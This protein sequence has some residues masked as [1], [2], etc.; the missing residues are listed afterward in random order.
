MEIEYQQP[1]RWQDDRF[2]LRFPMAT[3]PRYRPAASARVQEQ[4]SLGGGWE[5][6][7]GEVP[8][9]VPL[10]PADE[11]RATN[12]ISL[13]VNLDPGFPLG[14]LVSRYHEI[15]RATAADGSTEIRLRAGAVPADRDFL[16]E[17]TAAE[18]S[19]PRAA[20]FTEHAETGDYGL[21]MVMPPNVGEPS[22]IAREV[23]FIIDTSGSMGG[24]S[25]RQAK[26]A[27]TQAIRGLDPEDRFEVIEFSSQTRSLFAGLRNADDRYTAEALG[28]VAGL[29]ADGG[30]EMKP[31]LEAAFA[32][33][34]ADARALRQI[35]FI[36]D[37]AVANEAELL[38]L[39][40]RRLGG[41]RLFTVG[42]GSAPN[43]YFMTEAAHAGRGSFT[44]IGNQRE[45]AEKMSRL[46][47]QLEQPAMTDPSLSLPV[48]ADALPNPLP[49]LYQGQP[50]V[51]VMR[52]DAVPD[53]AEVSGRIGDTDWQSRLSLD[54]AQ[55]QAGLGVYWAR[56]K[57]RQWMRRLHAGADAEQVRSEVTAIGL[58]H[59]L[60]SAYT[61]L[62]AVDVT[63]IR[64]PDSGGSTHSIDGNLPA[65]W[66]P[67]GTPIH[68]GS[69]Q[70]LGLAQGATWSTL[71]TLLG[72]LLLGLAGLLRFGRAV[73][74]RVRA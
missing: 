62:V 58:S 32:I 34:D 22:V 7:P 43:S 47:R 40:R 72:G 15:D 17:W 31:A 28:Y 67:P 46:F 25:I 6:L 21:L 66:Q 49:D 4:I 29:D 30:T 1:L 33:P 65:G 60:V 42:I 23:V 39:I 55:E 8:N 57:I 19:T 59:H 12:P 18:S 11:T 64:P 45:V 20:F 73:L 36:T 63:P 48:V 24:A 69:A 9:R 16:L 14:E 44:F 53:Q 2:S 27:L 37:G 68:T 13:Q 70:S 5:I 51:A 50:L 56:A 61:S 41:R 54:A 71:Y 74:P 35:V 52:L 10:D 3:T 26:L 38:G